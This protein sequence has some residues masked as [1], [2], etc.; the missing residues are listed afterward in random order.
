MDEKEVLRRVI[1]GFELVP[2]REGFSQYPYVTK[3][4]KATPDLAKRINAW[5]KENFP[6]SKVRVAFEGV[7][8]TVNFYRA[9]NEGRVRLV[10][11]FEI[12]GPVRV[13]KDRIV[14]AY[15]F[16]EQNFA[17]IGLTGSERVRVRAHKSLK[18]KKTTAVSRY[19]RETGL[20]PNYK[21]ISATEENPSGLVD[22]NTAK[23]LE[24]K[25]MAEYKAKGW[26][27]LNLAPCGSLGGNIRDEYTIINS[28]DN[29]IHSTDTSLNA[30][31]MLPGSDYTVNAIENY[32]LGDRVFNRLEEIIKANNITSAKQL[33]NLASRR[34]SKL[35]EDWSAKHRKD[36]NWQKKLFP[37]TTSG[38]EKPGE[39]IDA[40]LAD[41]NN[42]D[43][44]QLKLITKNAWK[45]IDASKERAFLSKVKKIVDKYD[46]EYQSRNVDTRVPSGLYL[47]I[48]NHDRENKENKWKDRIFSRK[49]A[50]VEAK[51][52]FEH[53]VRGCCSSRY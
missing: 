37:E 49:K 15:T 9:M 1:Q 5:I 34:G 10:D 47:S 17:Y 4:G 30:L 24:C 20:E 51:K 8:R 3:T 23:D 40:F 28:L 29:F 38:R 6:Q 45:Q 12:E 35:I 18:A 48:L 50:T 44:D 26:Q 19:I 32:N 36:D 27:L 25:Y 53:I 42:L 39:G 41:P 43:R 13:P 21:I 14:Y 46:I 31:S 22:E 7:Y 52:I 33:R 2:A 11:L 16:P